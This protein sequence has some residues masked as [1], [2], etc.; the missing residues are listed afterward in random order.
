VECI[1]NLL[2]KMD[3]INK[4]LLPLWALLLALSALL[5]KA[6]PKSFRR[7]IR[8]LPKL[9]RAIWYVLL[10]ALPLT[11]PW[12]HFVFSWRR[13]YISAILL[14]LVFLLIAVAAYL[15]GLGPWAFRKN[16]PNGTKRVRA[17]WV[18]LLAIVLFLMWQ[19]HN[20]FSM[21]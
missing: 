21:R 10:G 6:G 13:D 17:I 18:T 19:I 20:V 3:V 2:P 4:I 9:V 1:L 16:I 7:N 8:N 15:G 14:T 11:W 5:V 12:L